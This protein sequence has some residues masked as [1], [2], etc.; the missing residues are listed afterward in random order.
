MN[1]TLFFAVY[2]L[3][4]IV[5]YKHAGHHLLSPWMPV[6]VVC[7]PVIAGVGLFAIVFIPLVGLAIIE[8][9]EWGVAELQ[10]HD[11]QSNHARF[12]GTWTPRELRLEQARKELEAF[13]A[14]RS[15]H[16]LVEGAASA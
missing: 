9:A 2:L 10:M 4:G 11:H 16:V 5:V 14:A 8:A 15:N 7:W 13:K 3:A 12:E 6:G 1:P